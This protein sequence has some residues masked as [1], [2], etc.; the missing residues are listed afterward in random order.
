MTP[1]PT[2][3][4]P[5]TATWTGYD[6]PS[7]GNSMDANQVV[8]DVF[9]FDVKTSVWSKVSTTPVG[10]YG[11][12][13]AVS[14]DSLILY[15]GFKYYDCDKSITYGNGYTENDNVPSIYDMKKNSWVSTYIPH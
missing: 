7:R 11:S 5:T 3:S 15:G 9:M 1:S 13:C 14:G 6:N 10:Y 12:A 2:G 4:P 8:N